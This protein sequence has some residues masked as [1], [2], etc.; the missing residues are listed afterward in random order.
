MRR[1]L[2]HS[3]RYARKY[4]NAELGSFCAK[5]VPTVVDQLGD[6]FPEIRKKEKLVKKILD[7]EEQAFAVSLDRGEAILNKYTRNCQ[8]R[9]LKDLPGADI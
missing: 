1:I 5:I 7:E 8:S 6:I 2:R 3:I 9:G 4:F